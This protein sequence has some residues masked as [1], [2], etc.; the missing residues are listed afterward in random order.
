MAEKDTQDRAVSEESLGGQQ[1]SPSNEQLNEKLDLILGIMKDFQG[2]LQT[3]QEDVSGL[4]EDVGG[5]KEDVGSLKAGQERLEGRVNNL[6]EIQKEMKDFILKIYNEQKI[7]KD[8]VKDLKEGQEVFREEIE[9]KF[10]QLG[11]K[12][13]TATRQVIDQEFQRLIKNEEWARSF[14]GK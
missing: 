5:L 4:K 2:S 8:D 12:M 7:L 6:E 14:W 3:V 13:T 1:A 9:R 10:S 11:L